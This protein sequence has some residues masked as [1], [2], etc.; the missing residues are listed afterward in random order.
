MSWQTASLVT[1]AG[2]LIGGGVIAVIVGEYRAQ[3][4]RE[5][6]SHFECRVGRPYFQEFVR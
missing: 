1:L 5:R 6:Y 4:R 2:L 3:K